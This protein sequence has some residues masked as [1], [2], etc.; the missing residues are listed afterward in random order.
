M[1]EPQNS[2]LTPEELERENGE[3]LPGREVMSVISDPSGWKLPPMLDG[4]PG[5]TTPVEPPAT[6]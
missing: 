2:E 1:T 3:A 6:E 5:Y 4:D